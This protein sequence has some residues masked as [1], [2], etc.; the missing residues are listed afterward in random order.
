MPVLT[1]QG[2]PILDQ[3]SN[4]IDTVR[5]LQSLDLSFKSQKEYVIELEEWT[6]VQDWWQDLPKDMLEEYADLMRK[7]KIAVGLK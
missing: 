4:T 5:R 1:E 2:R 6:R 7:S 3:L